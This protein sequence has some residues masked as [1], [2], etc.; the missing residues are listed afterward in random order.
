M[1]GLGAT[2]RPLQDFSVAA[3]PVPESI[4]GGASVPAPP[5]FV[6][7]PPAAFEPLPALPPVEV[8]PPRVIPVA[9][10]RPAPVVTVD[11]ARPSARDASEGTPESGAR[12]I[13]GSSPSVPTAQAATARRPRMVKVRK[14]R[15][16]DMP[17]P[18]CDP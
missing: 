4:A 1:L 17:R 5:L 14:E 3:H 16:Y 7:P 12:R 13:D 6:P 15:V 2:H 8:P 11:P 18:S 9:P 10:E